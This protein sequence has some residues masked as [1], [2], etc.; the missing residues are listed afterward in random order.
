MLPI[1]LS[2]IYR[3]YKQDTDSVARWLASTAKA[4]GYPA[5]FSG[6]GSQ[7]P[8]S[9]RLKGKERIKARA[10]AK[11][12][13]SSAEKKKPKHIIAIKDF[14]PLANFI[15]GRRNPAVS[16]PDVF[17]TTID[18]VI[19]LRSEYSGNLSH[20]GVLS[21]PKSDEQHGY[22]VGVLLAVREALRPGMASAATSL[23]TDAPENTCNDSLNDSSNDSSK[24]FVNR[25][26]AL[27]VDEP[28]D[29]FLEAFRN[30]PHERPAARDEDL[31]SYEAEPQ[32][33]LEDVL[34]AYMALNNDL[35]RIR[36]RIER[37]W[38][39]HRNGRLDL[40]SAAVAT[41]TAISM[42]RGLIEDVAPLLDTQEG[43][44]WTII[45]GFYLMT[46]LEKGYTLREACNVPGIGN[47]LDYNTY[48]VANECYIVAFRTLLSFTKVLKPGC[49]P[50]IKEGIF[51]KYDPTS[52]LASMTGREKFLE[53]ESLLMEFFTEL[54]AVIR[55]VPD[56]P[57]EDGFLREMRRFDKGRPPV[58]SFSLVFAAQVFLDINHTMR[59]ATRQSFQA[60]VDE[61]TI[62]SNSLERHLEFHENLKVE[63]WPASNDRV[64]KKLRHLMKSM[65][66]DPVHTAKVRAWAQTG[67]P[68]PPKMEPH[69]ILI[70]CPVLS[71][72][73][74]FRLRLEMYEI[75]IAIANAWGSVTYAAHLYNAL[76]MNGLLAGPWPDMEVML[77]TL[78][79]SNIW[80]GNER[81]KTVGDCH[82]KFCLQ[83]GVSAVSFT[84]N[85]RRNTTV[86]SR[87]GPRGI[88]EGAPVSSMFKTQIC[89]GA[90]VEWTPELLDDIVARSTYEQESMT[91][92]K[93]LT[94][95]QISDPQELR[96]RDRLRQEKA[97]ARTAG[98]AKAASGLAPDEL[99][100]KLALALES[101]SLEIAFPYLVM[102]RWCWKFLRSIKDAC[103]PVLRELWTPAY[104]EKETQLPWL[105]SWIL[106]A[107]A[108][109]GITPDLRP[110]H[111]AAR[112]C[113]S[114]I[115]S[116]SGK[117]AI[118]IA[119]R[120]GKEIEF[121][122]Q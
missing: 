56:Y 92:D 27:S 96:A 82:Q 1:Q 97:K 3:Q 58:V 120:I 66:E 22:F 80:V 10:G 60:L 116:E 62:M 35:H 72:L 63:H 87:A 4:C 40:A 49:I 103:D 84:K 119:R 51:G 73:Y 77:T 118:E 54:I 94:M 16:V 11:E 104:M 25:F 48:E 53:D 93:D 122:E 13:P 57:V 55:S 113:D 74:L 101:E 7:T 28:S 91:D 14:L 5:P 89:S 32:T 111:L 78:G 2:G 33:S 39:H 76:L 30:T 115:S 86:A 45:N 15:A 44:A 83:M 71:G 85:R 20:G 70:Y 17:L 18:R 99:I 50:L 61:V 26:A 24:G 46:C 23:A 109:V 67:H 36:H 9:G 81:P 29:A 42:A 75:G 117:L 102:H 68:A 41:N 108:G 64:L 95:R 69:L 8:K 34:F 106:M 12:G 88:K 6:L 59:A 79:Y 112:T 52:D 110:L 47:N 90:D 21:D 65:G 114:M 31:V 100:M 107:A 98:K 37:I 121:E 43:G 38:S 105:V 19:R